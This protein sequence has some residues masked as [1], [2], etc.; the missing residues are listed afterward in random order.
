LSFHNLAIGLILSVLIALAG[1][2]KRSLSRSGVAGAIL[3]GTIIFGLGGWI[4]GCLLIAFF[5]SSSL[6]SHYKLGEK[7]HLAD[8]FAKAGARDLGQALANGGW[9]AI[10]AI[11]YSL[12]PNP[13][14]F[15]AFVGAMSAVNADTW[16]TEVGVLSPSLPRLITNGRR[17]PVGTSG[18]ISPLGTIAASLGAL[19]IG[20]LALALA[21]VGAPPQTGEP[22]LRL[23]SLA[24]LGGLAGSLFDSLL[25]ATVQGIYYCEF[26]GKETEAPLHRCGRKARQVRGWRWL[27][28]DV[29]NFLSSIAGS[30][31]TA[32]GWALSNH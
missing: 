5:T 4:W 27:D 21:Q 25:G 26:C 11:L 18:A 30:L 16:A 32:A 3:I 24:A 23:A 20:L 15:I 22:C 1:Y 19:L 6:L 31:A 10:L 13:L 8:K 2:K 7:A 28:N 17:V 12:R 29:V 14:L 9:G